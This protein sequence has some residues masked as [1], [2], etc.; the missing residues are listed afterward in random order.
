MACRGFC[1]AENMLARVGYD[2]SVSA[3]IGAEKSRG[4]KRVDFGVYDFK[5]NSLDRV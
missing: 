2:V 1:S 5:S 3:W 4:S